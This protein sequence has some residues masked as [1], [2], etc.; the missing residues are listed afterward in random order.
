V[1]ILDRLERDG[2]DVFRRRPA[3]GPADAPVIVWRAL[4]WR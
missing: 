3:L 2:F 4:A 1:R